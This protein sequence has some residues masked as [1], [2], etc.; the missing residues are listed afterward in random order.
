M[1]LLYNARIYT[2]E[3]EQASQADAILL[4]AGRILAAGAA[5]ELR[6]QIRQA[7]DAEDLD[8][9]TVMP[10]LVDAHL[11]LEHYALGLQKVDCETG[12]LAECIR[13]VAQRA[14]NTPPGE[15]V[16]GHGW[17]Q[18]TWTQNSA[19]AQGGYPTAQDLDRAAPARPVYLTAKSLHAAW[20]NHAALQLAQIGADTPDPHGGRIGR[21]PSGCPNGILFESAMQLVEAHIPPPSEEQSAEAIQNALPS[22]WRFGLAGGHDFDGRRCFAALQRL[23]RQGKLRL[24]VIKGLPLEDLPHAAAIGLRGGFGDDWLRLGAVKLFADGALG[25]RTAAMLQ[26]YQG[27]ADNRGLLLLDAE[28]LVEYGR[29]AR[30]SGFALA[31]HAIGDRANHEALNA[32]AQLQEEARLA[33]GAQPALRHRIEHVQLLHPADAA[34]LA[35]LQV[36]ASMQPLHAPSDM[37]MADRFWGERAALAY[38]WRTQLKHG[39]ALAFG[40]DAPVESPNPWWGIHAAATRQEANGAP[41]PQ[42]WYPEQR[43]TLLE[44]LQAYTRGAAYAAGMEQIQGRLAA[45]CLADLV[46][47][48]TDPF[49]LA[50]QELRE[51]KAQRLMIGGEWVV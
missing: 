42:G 38:A 16:L 20:A 35:S 51:V 19:L 15:W 2:L 24:R 36:I 39:A 31:V 26:A 6:Q 46:V 33:P 10:A 21:D 9:A 14:A 3:T 34:R 40:S 23:H 29:L 5:D 11:H 27:E 44:A 7:R 41:G 50:A 47:L 18:N 22:L 12:S 48:N 32:F 28:Q 25:P 17:N 4:D 1:K 37:R 45:G 8:G 49:R 30:A 13:R 43:L